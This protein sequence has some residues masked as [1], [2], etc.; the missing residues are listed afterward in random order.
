LVRAVQRF[1]QT[2]LVQRGQALAAGCEDLNDH[3]TLRE[4]PALP[5]GS[6]IEPVADNMLASDSTLCRLANRIPRA[7]CV[8]LHEA[9]LDQF[10][11]SFDQPPE[12]WVL[13]R[14]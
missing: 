2:R 14:F 9:I 13:A 4:A 1:P 6:E 8:R 7:D 12:Q 11:G 5:L 3:Q 10:I